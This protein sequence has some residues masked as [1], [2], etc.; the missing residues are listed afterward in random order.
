[1]IR[2][3]GFMIGSCGSPKQVCLLILNVA[4][5]VKISKLGK[6]SRVMTEFFSADVNVESD[7]LIGRVDILTTDTHN[8]SLRKIMIWHLMHVYIH[9]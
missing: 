3:S 4:V 2:V 1:M 5:H 9:P 7:G 8:F 6:V